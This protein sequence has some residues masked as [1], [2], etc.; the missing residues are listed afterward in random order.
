MLASIEDLYAFKAD[1]QRTMEEYGLD[2]RL[3]L[4]AIGPR[5]AAKLAE[6]ERYGDKTCSR[7]SVGPEATIG[8]REAIERP[9]RV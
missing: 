6:T 8:D 3:D 9:E 1:V 7:R 2:V 5:Y 4:L